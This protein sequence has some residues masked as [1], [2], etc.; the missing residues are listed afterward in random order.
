MPKSTPWLAQAGHAV[1]DLM[2][3]VY[4]HAEVEQALKDGKP[5]PPEVLAD[6]PDLKPRRIRGDQPQTEQT[7]RPTRTPRY[8]SDA[9]RWQ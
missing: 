5:V 8:A 2:D 6:Y 3:K 4:H 9:L 7:A 1:P